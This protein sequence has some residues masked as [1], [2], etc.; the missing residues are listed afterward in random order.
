MI[1][2][3]ESEGLCAQH[4]NS[5]CIIMI[6]GRIEPSTL[7]LGGEYLKRSK[8]GQRVGHGAK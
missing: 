4:L 6:E 1:S 5:V 3:I 7:E 2:I 8:T